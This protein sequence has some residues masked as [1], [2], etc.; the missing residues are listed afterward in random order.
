MN[1]LVFETQ[2]KDD[3]M[4]VFSHR[5]DIQH[6][7]TFEHIHRSLATKTKRQTLELTFDLVAAIVAEHEA[8]G[9]VVF[10]HADGTSTQLTI[11]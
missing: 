6:I 2:K 9:A 1:D 4:R 3:E 11:K 7:E 8:G 5:V 10:H